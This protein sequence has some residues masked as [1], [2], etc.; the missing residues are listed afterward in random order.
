MWHRLAQRSLVVALGLLLLGGP[1]S[2]PLPIA[3]APAAASELSAPLAD[4]TAAP[5]V[6]VTQAIQFVL[7]VTRAGSGG[8]RVTSSPLG[9]YCLTTC[10]HAFD[11]GTVV[12]LTAYPDPSS[13]FTG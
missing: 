5:A 4:L 3:P 1:L 8:G 6:A 12:T 11:S 9:I 10:T 7:T 13:K 2:S